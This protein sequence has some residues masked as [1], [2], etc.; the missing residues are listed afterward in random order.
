ME[1][2][3]I[4]V[5]PIGFLEFYVNFQYPFLNSDEIVTAEWSLTGVGGGR[6]LPAKEGTYTW[7]KSRQQVIFFDKSGN[8]LMSF[9]QFLLPPIAW[10]PG[11]LLFGK[12]KGTALNWDAAGSTN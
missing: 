3:D 12:R 8:P 4:K 6:T 11:N 10:G 2:T 1:N 9:D 5:M 7:R